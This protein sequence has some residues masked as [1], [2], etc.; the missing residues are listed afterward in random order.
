MEDYRASDI[1]IDLSDYRKVSVAG[2]N[3][4]FLAGKSPRRAPFTFD[5]IAI[6]SRIEPEPRSARQ[7]LVFADVRRDDFVDQWVRP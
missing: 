7:F 4:G 1:G 5:P 2:M 3:G 6:A